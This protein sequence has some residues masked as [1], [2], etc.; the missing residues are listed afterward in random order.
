M[1]YLQMPGMSTLGTSWRTVAS[2]RSQLWQAQA[3]HTVME[4]RPGPACQMALL[5]LPGRALLQRSQWSLTRLRN[6]T[7]HMLGRA[8]PV[9]QKLPVCTA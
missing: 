2:M 6:L 1:C 5:R 7:S 4:H 3:M 9:T 8:M